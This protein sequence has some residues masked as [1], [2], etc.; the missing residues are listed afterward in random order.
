M[1]EGAFLSWPK[2]IG[3][4]FTVGVTLVGGGWL[5]LSSTLGSLQDRVES[6]DQS[7]KGAVESV[8]ENDTAL[9]GL[10]SDNT[11]ALTELRTTVGGLEK[12]FGDLS[13]KFDALNDNVVA[14]KASFEA[15][16]SRESGEPV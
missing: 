10:I 3:G 8:H 13:P 4:A 9:R 14:L 16:E 15:S 11:N 7:V 6:I 5:V 2:I 12:T 1:Q